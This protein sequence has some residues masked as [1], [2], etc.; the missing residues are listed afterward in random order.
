M[1]RLSSLLLVVFLIVACNKKKDDV[2][3]GSLTGKWI[4]KERFSSP[5]V[6]GSW[7]TLS[8]D[9]QFTIDFKS[10]SSFTYSANFPKADSLFS[11]Y[12]LSGSMINVSS[13][14]NSKTD[15]WFYEIESNGRLSLGIFMCFEGCSYGLYRID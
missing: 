6:G 2:F 4:A 1:T 9:Q 15:Q 10:D 12:R 5:G 14:A 13:L 3:N 8:I 7:N 11:Q